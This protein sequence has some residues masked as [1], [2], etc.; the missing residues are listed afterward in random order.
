M[1]T[2]SF[3]LTSTLLWSLNLTLIFPLRVSFRPLSNHCGVGCPWKLSAQRH[4]NW[5]SALQCHPRKEISRRNPPDNSNTECP[6]AMLWTEEAREDHDTNN[7]QQRLRAGRKT[8]DGLAPRK[9]A[10]GR[11][12]PVSTHGRGGNI[13]QEPHQL[14]TAPKWLSAR[15]DPT[16][17]WLPPTRAAPLGP[18][19]TPTDTP[20][21]RP[22]APS[23]GYT[24]PTQVPK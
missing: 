12:R 3:S 2:N 19:E 16:E 1:K 14:P 23:P 11:C 21:P 24:M 4:R 6:E 5:L 8:R 15:S 18:A 7:C 20:T 22:H 10:P 13:L 17:A 9:G